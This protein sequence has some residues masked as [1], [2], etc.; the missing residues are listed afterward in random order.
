MADVFD[1]ANR[2]SIRAVVAVDLSDRPLRQF[3]VFRQELGA[4][5]YYGVTGRHNNT[6]RR[7]SIA[8]ILT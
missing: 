3:V 1:I 4:R 8:E 7:Q 2:K 5:A 6:P